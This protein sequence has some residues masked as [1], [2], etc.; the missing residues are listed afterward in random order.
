MHRILDNTFQKQMNK[1]IK[2]IVGNRNRQ[3]A[4]KELVRKRPQQRLLTNN[5]QKS[6]LLSFINIQILSNFPSI[7]FFLLSTRTKNKNIQTKIY[8]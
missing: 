1:D 7:F 6:K 5:I 8:N 3:N 2:L 4:Q